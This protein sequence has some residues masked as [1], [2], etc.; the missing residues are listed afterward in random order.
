MAKA[1]KLFLGSMILI[2]YTSICI[3]GTGAT[4]YGNVMEHIPVQLTKTLRAQVYS[5][6]TQIR[7]FCGQCKCCPGSSVKTCYTTNCCHLLTCNGAK[8]LGS[9]IDSV[10]SCNC[11]ST[12]K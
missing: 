3:Q 8:P 9:C 6:P 4:K 12:C 1:T 2:L 11:D 10:L 5:G 7:K